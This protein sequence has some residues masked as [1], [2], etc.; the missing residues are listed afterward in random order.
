MC[1]TLCSIAICPYGS[2]IKYNLLYSV[3]TTKYDLMFQLYDLG[4][5]RG[6]REVKRVPTYTFAGK[7]QICNSLGTHMRK[8]IYF[9][10]N[11]KSN[12]F[13]QTW[14]YY[15]FY[16]VHFTIEL[17]LIFFNLLFA[18]FCNPTD[19]PDKGI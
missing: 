19:R 15:N 4:L 13:P 1:H 6:F 18:K 12:V 14:V 8:T 9:K 2:R 3:F 5:K 11:Y 16:N 7:F 17:S 10:K